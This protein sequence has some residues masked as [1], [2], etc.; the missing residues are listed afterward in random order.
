MVCEQGIGWD[1]P[2]LG[3]G[4]ESGSNIAAITMFK[5]MGIMDSLAREICQNSLDAKD[6]DID[7]LIP[8]KVKFE[9]VF[10]DRE[11][12]SIFQDY[13]DI[14]EE[15]IK[16][17]ENHPLKTP[18]IMEF[19]DD[20]RNE[21]KKSKIPVLVIS[22][23]NTTGLNGVNASSNERSYW[24]LLVNTEGISIKQDDN[25]AGSY[26]IGKN[27]PFAYSGLNLVFYNT[28]AKDEGRAFE[29]VSRLLTTQK[30]VD[31]IKRKTQPIG[32][33]LYIED[34]YS[35]RPILPSDKCV[36][37]TQEIFNRTSTGTDVA[38]V[39]FKI[40]DFQNWEYLLAVAI[41]KNFVVALKDGF[42]EITIKS[43]N[44]EYI[45]SKDSLYD[46]LYEAFKNEDSLKYTRQI[47]A[48][49]EDPDHKED[50]CIADPD[51][52]NDLSIYIKY[53]DSYYQSMSRFRNGMLINTTQESL[54]HYS[55]V[56]MTKD[57]GN[58]ENSL[59]KVLRE[60]EPP[61][62]TEWKAKNI[63]NN[64]KLHNIAAKYLRKIRSEIQ[65]ILD[66]FEQTEIKEIT[67]SGLNQIRNIA[68]KLSNEN[69][70]DLLKTEVALEDNE[71]IA[72]P[73]VSSVQY[74]SAA[75]AVGIVDEKSAYKDG[76]QKKK[77]KKKRKKITVVTPVEDNENHNNLQNGVTIDRGE[78]KIK[79]IILEKHRTFAIG[80]NK[81]RIVINS[82]ENYKNVY[83]RYFA[84]REDEGKDPVIIKNIKI[85]NEP[86]K[87]I[88]KNIVGPLDFKQ[89]K[90]TLH[91]EFES[92][93]LMALIPEY[94][95]E[96]E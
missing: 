53:D 61:Q 28:L 43:E 23:F 1:F 7:A 44:L 62:H 13:T 51:N 89:G 6:K 80:G 96:V 91:I 88:N 60:S 70:T 17:W 82:P 39:G 78:L 47:Y 90:N 9:L 33:Y 22:D 69:N 2:L 95:M 66:N 11:A 64:R 40:D 36:L 29:G 84:G 30:L 72:V 26:G 55:V 87:I 5:G 20:V 50:V 35:G 18:E 46:F 19:L 32:K 63:T 67:D 81:Y 68:G 94:S 3:N 48:T 52:Q 24:N 37:A 34:M 77:K 4:N 58:G 85:E 31:G 76:E 8:V 21:S 49:L 16:Y 54:P 79:D 75:S 74:V 57:I 71:F 38:V 73:P 41:I 12:F 15:S 42:L 14:V 56:I 25:S 59:S 86:L 93:E 83:I 65:R 45:I 10:L 27:A 92:S